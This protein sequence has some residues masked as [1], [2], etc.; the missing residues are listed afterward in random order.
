MW[1][2][3]LPLLLI[4]CDSGTS[5]A[6]SETKKVSLNLKETCGKIN[7]FKMP[8]PTTWQGYLEGSKSTTPIPLEWRDSGFVVPCDLATGDSIQILHIF[9]Q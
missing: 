6:S 1:K 8:K 4:A 7:V 3:L 2:M 9:Y 5:P